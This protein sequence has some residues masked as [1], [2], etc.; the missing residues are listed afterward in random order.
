L[1]GLFYMNTSTVDA[2]AN[3]EQWLA[4]ALR[5][6]Q[7]ARLEFEARLATALAEERIEPE[8]KRA[9]ADQLAEEVAEI[10]RKFADEAAK[11]ARKRVPPLR[12]PQTSVHSRG[13]VRRSWWPFRRAG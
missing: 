6:V 8:N 11:V 12:P 4:D 1:A 5:D 9:Q 3:F 7:R 10:A 2:L 13:P